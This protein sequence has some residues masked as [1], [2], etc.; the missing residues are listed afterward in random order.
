MERGERIYASPMIEYAAWMHGHTVKI[1]YPA[2]M[3]SVW[4]AG[5]YARLVGN[6]GSTN[7]LH[8]A[9]PTPV[10][11]RGKRL[12]SDSVMLRLR[13]GS[14]STAVTSVH[15][16]DGENRIA[17]HDGLS[18]SPNAFGFSRF[19]IAGKPDV[20]W[21][22]GISIGVR[23]NGT[24]DAQNTLE[25]ASAGCD[26]MLLETV[27]VHFK[28]LVAPTTFTIDQMLD[29]MRQVYEPAGF[30]VVR[31]S[32][33]TLN[34]PD[35][36]VVDVGTCAGTTTAEQNTLF[37]N[38]NNAGPNDLCIY[39]V[40]ATNPPLNGCAT[41]PAGQ[42]GSV[43]A[44]GASRWTL[45]HEIGHNLGLPHCDSPGARLFDRLM[46]GGGTGN[47]TN[48]PPD[49]VASEITTMSSSNLSINP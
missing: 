20:R 2:R 23:F 22:I 25:L 32:D 30:R 11:V 38:R 47:I 35:L 15:V 43:V 45:G 12:M 26:F 29:G 17:T 49:L 28:T 1:E 3:K 40:Q 13:A 24:T 36:N 10:I 9:V 19:N 7:W 37:A 39:F 41:D 14:T 46:T 27:R 42:P 5:F 34:L 8:F 44:S 4:R 6:P 18:L 16:Y 33:E 31:A 48:P 21:G